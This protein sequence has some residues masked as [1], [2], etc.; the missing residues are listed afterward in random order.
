MTTIR[1]FLAT[2]PERRQVVHDV[3]TPVQT[4][5]RD[6]NMAAAYK[7][8]APGEDGRIHT[9]LSVATTSGRLAS[10][11]STLV[12][13]SA[14][15][16]QNQAN[17]VVALDPLYNT[18]DVMCADYGMQLV[19]RDYAGAEALLVFAYSGDWEWVDILLAGESIHALHAKEFFSLRCPADQVKKKHPEVYTTSKNIGFLSF[20]SGSARTAAITFNKD[21][22]IHGQRITEKEVRRLQSI[23]YQLHPLEAWWVSVAEEI[24][25]NNGS[26]RNCFGMR[27]KLRDPDE[28]NRLKDA[29]AQLPQSTVGTLTNRSIVRIHD[30]LDRDTEIELLHQNHDEVVVQ[31]LPECLDETLQGVKD[32]MEVEFEINGRTLAIPTDAKVGTVG[33]SW[34]SAKG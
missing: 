9:A 18:R 33:G 14:T 6:R 13:E 5:K 32:I 17:K 27:R 24:R 12:E 19:S 1:Q 26:I 4:G 16:L 21:Y 10:S 23:L 8:L 30:E 29:L 3:L 20:Y 34:G 25:R 11:G 31:C 22:L 15:N 7:R 28:H 2:L